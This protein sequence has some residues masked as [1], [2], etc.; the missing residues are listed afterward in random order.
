MVLGRSGRGIQR[1]LFT[2]LA[3]LFLKM[4]LTPNTITIAGTILT[5]A[6]AL[7]LLPLGYLITGSL[8]L[9]VLVLAD[10]IDGI[11]ARESGSASPFGAFLD[12]TLDRIADAAI[13]SGVLLW[14]VF[15]SDGV[16]QVTGIA[17]TLA[18]LAFGAIVPYVRAKAES[19]G[20]EASVGLAER[21]DRIVVVLVTTLMTGLGVPTLVF[22]VVLGLLAL[23]SFVTVLQRMAATKAGLA[24]QDA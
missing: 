3:R 12:S 14:F 7:T 11:M 9:G 22:V 2:P 8:A 15:N 17:F 10:S 23:A 21:A 18:T 20:V 4:G 24:Q 16:V 6:V 5:T 13:F 1:A 19:L